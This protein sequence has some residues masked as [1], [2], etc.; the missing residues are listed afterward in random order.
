M[1]PANHQPSWKDRR[2]RAHIS[3]LY[4]LAAGYTEV[5]HNNL[6]QSAR[7]APREWL[8]MAQ[9]DLADLRTILP[10]SAPPIQQVERILIAGGQA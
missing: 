4:H 2:D 1:P 10:Q 7:H 9:Q 6:Y 3:A 5:A 8:D